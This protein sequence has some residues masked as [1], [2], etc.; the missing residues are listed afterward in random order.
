MPPTSNT[1]MDNPFPPPEPTD[2]GEIDRLPATIEEFCTTIGLGHDIQNC[3]RREGG[4]NNVVM[5]SYMPFTSS[6]PN[7]PPH[8]R[9]H[10]I[11]RTEK[12]VF[13][14]SPNAECE[15][16]KR[17]VALA[18]VCGEAEPHPSQLP[19]PA[20]LAYDESYDN[21]IGC[22]Y[23]VQRKAAGKDLA[24][25]YELLNVP[26]SATEQYHLKE[27]MRVAEEMAKF[28]AS[29][30]MNFQYTAYGLLVNR[31]GML[32]K[33]VE[34]LEKETWMGIN[35]RLVG[36]VWIP[37]NV[38]HD[39]FIEGLINVHLQVAYE[40]SGFLS[41]E[42]KD[43]VKLSRIFQEM[44]DEGLMDRFSGVTTLWHPD[45][46]PRNVVFDRVDAGEGMGR[47]MKLTAVIDW[48]DALVLPR[49]MIRKPLKW[50]WTR[51]CLP[52]ESQAVIK[53]HF[54]SYMESLVPG[55]RGEAEGREAI[56][57]RAVFAYAFWGTGYRSHLEL[58][59]RGLLREWKRMG[60]EEE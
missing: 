38:Q 42:Y 48:D 11:L 59:F 47:E 43:L 17:I 35:P 32:G 28:L 55:Y 19:I 5:F 57:M 15:D 23:I 46:Y 52:E 34:G 9:Q 54:Y 37:G 39:V 26:G 50:I 7:H 6:D 30:E 4:N 10:C 8:T 33:S 53:D 51:N 16:T 21:T 14:N 36:N 31:R 3:E 22:P 12:I 20:V 56:V 58:S 44:R 45:L 13:T 49:Y 29:V 40:K 25:W 2:L 27:R 18:Q 41:A 1:M 24:R 60:E